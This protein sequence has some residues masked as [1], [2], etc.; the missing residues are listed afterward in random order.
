[1]PLF[2]ASLMASAFLTLSATSQAGPRG[3]G[4]HGASFRGGFVAH[5]AVPA[6]GVGHGIRGNFAFHRD[7]AFHE[8]R[9]FFHRDHRVFLQ[10]FAWPVYWYPYYDP[11]AYSYLDYG[12]DNDYQYWDDSAAPVQPESFKRAVDHSPIVI[13]INT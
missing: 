3:G 12:P 13:V 11:F 10:Q 5:S 4:F 7:F 2:I 1:M 6:F 9:R 8:N